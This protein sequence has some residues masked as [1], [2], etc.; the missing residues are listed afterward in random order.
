MAIGR[1]IGASGSTGGWGR[2]ADRRSDP[3]PES[4][5]TGYTRDEL[6]LSTRIAGTD[7][8]AVVVLAGGRLAKRRSSLDP[9]APP[10][11]PLARTGIRR[12]ARNW[13]AIVSRSAD[14]P[15][16][17]LVDRRQGASPDRDHR[18]V[19]AVVTVRGGERLRT[20]GQ[21][22]SRDTLRRLDRA[23]PGR[24]GRRGLGAPT[25][26]RS[27]GARRH[28]LK[29]CLGSVGSESFTSWALAAPVA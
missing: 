17:G 1:C 7:R 8:G 5:S 20:H 2:P 14:R 9:Y 24:V 13:G 22:A 21:R 18:L 28:F 25:R 3:Q 19:K 29:V 10:M 23:A 26:G 12:S 16:A 15:G 6:R 4:G 27:P 11:Q